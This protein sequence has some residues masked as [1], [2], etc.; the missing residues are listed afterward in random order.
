[1][2]NLVELIAHQKD[3]LGSL[4]L[5]LGGL[6][7]MAVYVF[8]ILVGFREKSYAI[9]MMALVLNFGWEFT[10][11]FLIHNP[12]APAYQV[13][14]NQIWSLIDVGI[15]VS[16]LRYGR[17]YFPT[18]LS[19]WF[20]P[21]FAVALG[22]S[23]AFQ[24]TAYH[25]FH[26]PPEIPFPSGLVAFIMNLLMSILFLMMLIKRK[27][28][29][30]QSMYIAGAK[31]LGTFVTYLAVIY[32]TDTEPWSRAGFCVPFMFIATTTYDLTYVFLL[33]RQ[34]RREGKNPWRLLQRKEGFV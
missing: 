30:G 22:F 33:H 10:Y 3:L 28:S 27:S 7:W 9:P 12:S 11:G 24:W 6:C 34:F 18:D 16:Y 29:E 26:I 25:Y 1:M 4:L 31:F 32:G 14:I 8:S 19:D 15:I 21:N 2:H 13:T 20:Y 5:M 17:K 23:F